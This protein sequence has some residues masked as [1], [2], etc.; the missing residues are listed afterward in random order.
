L[1]LLCFSPHPPPHP[2]PLGLPKLKIEECAARQ[3]AHIDSGAEVIVGVNKFISAAAGET[4]GCSRPNT[5]CGLTS[6]R[7]HSCGESNAT[8]SAGCASFMGIAGSRQLYAA[9]LPCLGMR[10]HWWE[11]GEGGGGWGVYI[12]W[13]R[14]S[15]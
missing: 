7:S 2:I 15:W 1:L 13:R 12:S 10:P 5:A 6:N 4:R 11:E 9:F 3:Q 14:R 8:A